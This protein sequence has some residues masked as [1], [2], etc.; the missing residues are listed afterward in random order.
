MNSPL[1]DRV[2][3]QIETWTFLPRWKGQAPCDGTKTTTAVEA[4]DVRATRPLSETCQDSY[5]P[6]SNRQEVT[7]RLLWR[8]S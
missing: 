2:E 7:G 8:R 1:P 6:G 5:V 3:R 4:M